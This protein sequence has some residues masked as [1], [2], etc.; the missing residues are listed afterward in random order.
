MRG[1]SEKGT[2]QK[3]PRKGGHLLDRPE[4]E[5]RA[6]SRPVMPQVKQL[7]EL[8]AARAAAKSDFFVQW[9]LTEKCNLRCRHCYQGHQ[10]VMMRPDELSLPEI[11]RAAEETRDAF[12]D[13]AKTYD[14]EFSPS[15]NLTGGEPFLRADLFHVIEELGNLGFGINLLT[16]GTLVSP[17]RA[18][19]LAHLGVKAVQVSMEGP[20]EVHDRIRGKGSFA[21]AA[22]G[23]K[24]L[25]EAGLR[26]TLNITLSRLNAPYMMDIISLAKGLG[27]ARVGFSR[28]VPTG[29][30]LSMLGEMLKPEEVKLLYEM[31][32]SVNIPGIEVITGDPLSSLIGHGESSE[33]GCT[34]FGGCAAGVSGLTFLPDGT[35]T[36]CRRLHIPIGNI[37]TD[38]IREVWAASEVLGSLRDRQKYSGRCRSCR[39][40]AACRGCRAIA[41]ASTGAKG[42]PDFLAEDPQCFIHLNGKSS[43]FN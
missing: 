7:K 27:V 30:G 16:N 29:R 32:L 9:H 23:A 35:I 21:K 42:S 11:R 37:R 28:L 31:L 10:A 8:K 2:K 18:K 26:V 3:G 24:S 5:A 25:V 39:R 12:A 20:E 13:W 15:F 6:G 1:E 22:R 33:M 41:Y 17:E 36:P 19:K 4:K 14:I 40:W 38:S 43:L 34:A